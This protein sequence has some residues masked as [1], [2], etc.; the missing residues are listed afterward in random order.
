MEELPENLN[1]K[2]IEDRIRKI[3]K[4]ELEREE[5]EQKTLLQHVRRDFCDAIENMNTVTKTGVSLALS[6]RLTPA[7]KK[8]FILE[9]ADRFDPIYCKNSN[10]D[11]FHFSR[12]IVN[13]SA[14]DEIMIEF[15]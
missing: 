13:Y 7:S 9:V 3:R 6:D 5:R 1:R 2:A 12:D 11:L 8:K 15:C 10:A 4:E 14:I